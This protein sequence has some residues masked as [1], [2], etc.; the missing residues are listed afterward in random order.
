MFVVNLDNLLQGGIQAGVNGIVMYFAV[1]LATRF[2]KIRP[3]KQE[4]KDK[5]K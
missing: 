2:E 3:P 5:K 1:K 4:K